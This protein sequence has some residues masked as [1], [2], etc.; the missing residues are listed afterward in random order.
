MYNDV[1][2]T[3][4]EDAACSRKIVGCH[5]GDVLIQFSLTPAYAFPPPKCHHHRQRLASSLPKRQPRLPKW[6]NL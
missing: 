5:L 6:N 4:N 1:T 2:Y 3:A